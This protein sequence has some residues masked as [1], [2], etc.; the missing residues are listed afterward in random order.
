M[1]FL[2]GIHIAQFM[3]S[4]IMGAVVVSLS[5]HIMEER[6]ITEK[7]VGLTIIELAMVN[8]REL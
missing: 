7:L 6:R 3:A 1:K 4:I 5:L 8:P 2:I